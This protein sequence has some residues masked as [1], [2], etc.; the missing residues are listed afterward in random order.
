M[1][2]ET[3]LEVEIEAFLGTIEYWFVRPL[4]RARCHKTVCYYLM[5]PVGGDVSLHDDEFDD[6][7]WFLAQDALNAVTY[8]NEARIVEKSLPL[9]AKEPSAG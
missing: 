8:E 4:D 6:V 2:E 7:R 1:T 5:K 9:A 3:G